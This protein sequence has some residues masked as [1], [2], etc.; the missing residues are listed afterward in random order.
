MR[1]PRRRRDRYASAT[2]AGRASGAGVG[3][4]D[5]LGAIMAEVL[6]LRVRVWKQEKRRDAV[7]ISN[8]VESRII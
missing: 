4:N 7:D 1:R 5:E 6:V 2:S 8:W 3:G